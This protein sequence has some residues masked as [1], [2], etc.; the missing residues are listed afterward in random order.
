MT[1]L[2]T[3]ELAKESFHFSAAHFTL[4]SA[5]RREKLHGHNYQVRCSI[6]CPVG[7]EDLAFDYTPIKQRLNDLCASL[8]ECTLMPTDSPWLN[9][10]EAEGQLV[11]EFN[12]QELR[13]PSADVRLLPIANV[14]LEG[15]AHYLA[16]SLLA[17]DEAAEWP[18]Q[19]LSL[20]VSS[21]PGV[22]ADVRVEL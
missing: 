9:V 8:D 4:F 20:G 14:T 17:S 15:L 3:I 19:S 18:M 16:E 21:A 6:H 22:W 2:I 7:E 12:D 1:G 11:I 13:L 10:R 5:K